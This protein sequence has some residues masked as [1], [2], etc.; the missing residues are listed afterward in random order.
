MSTLEDEVSH[1]NDSWV[2]RKMER[3]KEKMHAHPI[4]KHL[5]KPL[6][7][8]VGALC[9]IAGLI[10]LVTPGPGWLFIFIGLSIWAT[11]FVWAHKLYNRMMK[12]VLTCWHKIQDWNNQRKA[13]R[14]ARK[15]A[16]N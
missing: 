11:E 6:V 9:L 10:M 1:S 16:K 4:M 15:A 5:Y 8:G 3:M 12:I 13:K 14:E 2:H 7:I